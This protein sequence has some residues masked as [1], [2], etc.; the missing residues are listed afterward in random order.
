MILELSNNLAFKMKLDFAIAK[1]ISLK[2]QR[3]V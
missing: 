1:A 3:F 2:A